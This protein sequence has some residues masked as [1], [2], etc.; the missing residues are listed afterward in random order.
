MLKPAEITISNRKAAHIFSAMVSTGQL[1]HKAE[2]LIISRNTVRRSRMKHCE[3]FTSEIK[4][5]F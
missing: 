3:H 2:E 5:T 4:A 1:N